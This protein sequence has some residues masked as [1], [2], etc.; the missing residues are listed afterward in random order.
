MFVLSTE[1]PCAL[2]DLCVQDCITEFFKEE[3][4]EKCDF[5]FVKFVISKLD[6]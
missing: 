5:F 6:K 1:I 3:V 2:R 4:V